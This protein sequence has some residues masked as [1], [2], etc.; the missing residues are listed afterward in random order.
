MLALLIGIVMFVVACDWFATNVPPIAG[1]I[2]Q[3]EVGFA[4]LLVSFDGSTSIDPDGR[5][6]KLEWEFGDGES[7]SGETCTHQYSVAGEYYVRLRVKDN[8]WKTTETGKVVRVLNPPPLARIQASAVTGPSPLSV[9]FDGSGSTDASGEITRY[10]WD[11]GDGET[12]EGEFVTHTYEGANGSRFEV[13]LT[14]IDDGGASS[15]SSVTIGLESST[16]A[17]QPPI[18]D[19]TAAPLYGVA[20][21]VVSCNAGDSFDIDGTIVDYEWSFGDGTIGTGAIVE[22]TYFAPGS[23]ELRLIIRDD[24]GV[25]ASMIRTVVVEV[26]IPSPPPPPG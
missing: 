10:E 22:H 1:F 8:R 20:P 2:C 12:A 14:V 6:R 15:S 17:N 19:F 26:V 13:R 9:N 18:A 11:F 7:A 4:P 23:H 3:P 5:I 16:G 21:L 25:E 24:M